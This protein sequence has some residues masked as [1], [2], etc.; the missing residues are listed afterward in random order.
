PHHQNEPGEAQIPDDSQL[1]LDLCCLLVI[2]LAP[3]LARALEN[4][5]AQK[6]VVVVAGGNRKLW[7]RRPHPGKT[8]I[9]FRCDS[10]ALDQSRLASFPA[11]CHLLGRS[12]PPLAIRMQQPPRERVV[13]GREI[14]RASCRERVWVWG[15]AGVAH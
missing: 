12:E 11:L 6:R 8:E 5:L 1:V 9:A 13:D 15:G 4:F 10:L 2:D 14:G 7:Q 3:P